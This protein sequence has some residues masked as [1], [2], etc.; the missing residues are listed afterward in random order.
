MRLK[1]QMDEFAW[2]LI[3]ALVFILIIT[4]VWLPSK[5]PAPLVDPK[6]AEVN[7]AAGSTTSFFISINGTAPGKLSN[8]TLVPLGEIKGWISFDR[9]NFDIEDSAKVKVTVI[10]PRVAA[11]TYTGSIKIS[12]SGGESSVSLRINV[13]SV[14]EVKSRPIL[15]GDINI[16]YSVGSESLATRENLEIVKSYFTESKEIISVSIPS[17]KLSII[18]DG[19]VNLTVKETNKQGNLIIIFNENELLNKKVGVS[20]LIIPIEKALINNTNS[21]IIQAT[22]PGFEFWSKSVYKIEV[23]FVVNYQDILERERI[24]NLTDSEIANFKSFRLTGK[25]K[26]YSK[27]LQELVIK[28]NNQL[29]Y[30]NF[31]PLAFINET[32]EKDILG[33]MLYLK[34]KDNVISFSFESES[35]Y[36][37]ENAFLMVYYR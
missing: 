2:I 13:V 22:S 1:A 9:N 34:T 37:L 16:R 15:L 30:S 33:D 14:A 24:F 11:R 35:Y 28:I 4:V 6:S 23:S 25:V 19:Y 18:T 17:E 8:V 27:P 36:K 5:E 20:T 3:G 12:S 21:L 31:P 29:V 10:A 7:L 32:F 26:E